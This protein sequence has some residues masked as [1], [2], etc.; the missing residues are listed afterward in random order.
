MPFSL[1]N[2]FKKKSKTSAVS[3]SDP[4]T[5]SPIP[6]N[7]PSSPLTALAVVSSGHFD[8]PQAVNRAVSDAQASPDDT[9][10]DDSALVPAPESSSTSPAFD[11]QSNATTNDVTL[12]LIKGKQK[13]RAEVTNHN[14]AGKGAIQKYEGGQQF[15]EHVTNNNITSQP[16][17]L[18]ASSSSLGPTQ[19]ITGSQV[20]YSG[21]T[22][23]NSLGRGTTQ[24]IDGDQEF[25]GPVINNN[26][27]SVNRNN[28]NT[29][30]SDNAQP[31]HEAA[32]ASALA[33]DHPG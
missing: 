26:F 29:T 20:Y 15:F 31:I 22:T 5:P 2:L 1:T 33:T 30:P 3:D 12:H 27:H 4:L 13:F 17:P 11:S 16:L 9:S 21:M 10:P 14:E 28:N 7:I 19:H 18:T 24:I 6:A 23:N 32:Q 25:W 8:T